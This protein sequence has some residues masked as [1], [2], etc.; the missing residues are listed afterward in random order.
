MQELEEMLVDV[1]TILSVDIEE[2]KSKSRKEELVRARAIF[3]YLARE[4]KFTFYKIADVLIKDH[5][6]I[7]HLMKMINNRDGYLK[8]KNEFDKVTQL[9]Y[10]GNIRTSQGVS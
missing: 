10:G 3:S 8:L 7:I 1:C 6:T 4:K 9:V 5:S 2:V